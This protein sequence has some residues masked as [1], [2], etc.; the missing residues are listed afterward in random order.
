MLSILVVSSSTHFLI[1][2]VGHWQACDYETCAANPISW[3]LEPRM[4][5]VDLFT[6]PIPLDLLR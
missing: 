3:P 1:T 4:S 6:T 2:R 5:L